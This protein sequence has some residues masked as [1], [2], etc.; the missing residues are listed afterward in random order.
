MQVP[1]GQV[2][3]ID[4]IDY[5]QAASAHAQKASEYSFAYT[6][7]VERWDRNLVS[8]RNS[9]QISRTI[10]SKNYFDCSLCHSSSEP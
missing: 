6:G 3:D 7:N 2:E 9:T 5:Y 1:M 8:I 10:W 4:N